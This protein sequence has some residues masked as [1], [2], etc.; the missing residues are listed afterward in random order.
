MLVCKDDIASQATLCRVM[1]K[2]IYD[3]LRNL[4]F[5][6][7]SAAL[8]RKLNEAE[9]Q[10]RGYLNWLITEAVMT[11]TLR[12]NGKVHYVRALYDVAFRPE[13]RIRD[14]ENVVVPEE[15][16]HKARALYESWIEDDWGSAIE[17]AANAEAAAA[18]AATA[19]A[20]PT[21]GPGVGTAA[22][23]APAPRASASSGSNLPLVTVTTRVPPLDH[24]IWG[25]G[26]IMFGLMR[27]GAKR[28]SIRYN[29]ELLHIKREHPATKYGHNGI[30]VGA[31][32]PKLLAAAFHGC[33][34]RSQAGISGDRRTGAYSVVISGSGG[35]DS[36]DVDEGERVIYSGSGSKGNMDPDRVAPRTSDTDTLAASIVSRNPVRVIRGPAGST[37]SSKTQSSAALR[38]AASHRYSPPEG[39]RYDGLYDVRQL[40][41]RRNTNGGLYEA[42]LLVRRPGQ[43]PLSELVRIPTPAQLRDYEKIAAGY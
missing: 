30:E 2:H 26:G 13:L 24:P 32:Y 9:R 29:T 35:Y 36:L 8:D 34:G 15:I 17:E 37:S 1:G 20:A 12:E 40:L 38:P 21:R 18:A 33:H 41:Q 25:R 23:S 42:F 28:D 16:S 11:P 7:R 31:W 14:C 6:D 19:A 10:V 4:R 22:A 3:Y 39:Y 27:G 43:T 5:V